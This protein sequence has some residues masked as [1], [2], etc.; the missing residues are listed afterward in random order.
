MEMG[1]AEEGQVLRIEAIGLH[2]AARASTIGRDD[3]RRRQESLHLESAT[4]EDNIDR[5]DHNRRGKRITVANALIVTKRV[6]GF[7]SQLVG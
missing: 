4:R 5:P 6:K 7:V 2:C 3:G 1:N